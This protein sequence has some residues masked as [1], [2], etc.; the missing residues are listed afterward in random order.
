[1]KICVWY[2]FVPVFF[3][4][5]D[6]WYNKQYCILQDKIVSFMFMWNN[7]DDL[8]LYSIYTKFIF[9]FNDL[10]PYFVIFTTGLQTW[11]KFNQIWKLI[12]C[13]DFCYVT[14]PWTWAKCNKIWTLSIVETGP[15]MQTWPKCDNIW[16]LSNVGDFC[17]NVHLFTKITQN[18]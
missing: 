6:I 10:V 4:V 5:D 17:D 7:K 12:I 18:W 13:C 3:F 8:L 16:T 11:P 14:G 15:R 9:C 2:I 1:M